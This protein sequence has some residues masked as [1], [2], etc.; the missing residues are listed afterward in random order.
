M[1]AISA[2]NPGLTTQN[3]F[4][5]TGT[6][7]SST[8]LDTG[9]TSFS[10]ILKLLD[11]NADGQTGVDELKFGAGFMVNN[12][13]FSRDL[14]QDWMLSAEEAGAPPALINYFDTDGDQMLSS[15]EIITPANT[16]IDG[17]FSVLDLNG[18]NSLSSEEAGIIDLISGLFSMGAA[19]Q[20]SSP[21]DVEQ[22]LDLDT[23]PDRMRQAGFEGTDNQLY[24]ALASTYADWP[25]QP[26]PNDPAS[27]KLSDQREDIYKWFDNI[28]SG[29]GR[30]MKANPY[31]T[32]S[33]VIND[34]PDRLGARLGP[35]IM[36]K[37]SN[38]GDRVQM[39]TLYEDTTQTVAE[40]TA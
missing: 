26:D 16:V 20:A 34:G 40:S 21:V 35:A 25:W 22:A 37:L 23:L 12:L 28:V 15:K 36:K 24:Y 7:S 13:V 29:V 5:A 2:I 18:D 4:G 19:G 27:I 14:N 6:G 3:I 17:V 11:T 39:G 32:A 38:F 31:L 33:A 1:S 8:S 30:Q 10:D 9:P